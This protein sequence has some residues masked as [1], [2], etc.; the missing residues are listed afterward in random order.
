M[1]I[2]ILLI[3]FTIA[4][5]YLSSVQFNSHKI[6]AKTHVLHPK[7]ISL[8]L[9][10]KTAGKDDSTAT[11][12]TQDVD[13]QTIYANS[14]H[15]DI[16]TRLYTLES[17]R[18]VNNAPICAKKGLRNDFGFGLSIPLCFASLKEEVIAI[19]QW[20]DKQPS[21]SLTAMLCEWQTGKTNYSN[22]CTEVNK[23]MSLS[24]SF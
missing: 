13:T 17:S 3:F 11:T 22:G 7:G 18:G 4:S 10:N 9:P 23:F 2:W 6:L 20:I 12:F 15:G 24:N 8:P 5:F 16:I 19:D 21:I 1:K 14:K